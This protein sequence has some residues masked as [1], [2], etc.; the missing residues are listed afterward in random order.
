MTQHVPTTQRD[1][2]WWSDKHTS[3]WENVKGALERDWEQTKA[4]FSKRGGHKLNQTVSDT[5][6]QAVGSEPVPPMGVKTRPTELKDAAKDE[7]KA[8]ANLE[9]VSATSAETVSNAHDEMD[10]DRL[11]LQAKVTDVRLDLSIKVVEENQKADAGRRDAKDKI[12]DVK[13]DMAA[14]GVKADEKIAEVK[15]ELAAA[16]LKASEKIVEVRKDQATKQEKV[17]DEITDARAKANEDIA[18]AQDTAVAGI[19]K[20]QAR[21]DGARAERDVAV[22]EWRDAEFEVRYGY[23]LR[24]QYIAA[25]WNDEL[26]GKV[27]REW[28]ALATGKAWNTSRS[29]IRRGWEYAGARV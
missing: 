3:T 25:V 12:A 27:R 6:N 17:N 5:I 11:A 29:E 15:K 1:P 13:K 7:E 23:A 9:K 22:G 21:I 26:E 8:R 24:T 4:D 19:A 14:A 2:V 16:G 20:E 28:D 18:C 10:Q